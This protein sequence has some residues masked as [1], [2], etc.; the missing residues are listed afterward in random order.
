[1]VLVN[2]DDNQFLPGGG[3]FVPNYSYPSAGIGGGQ[4][5]LQGLARRTTL[6]AADIAARDQMLAGPA[7]RLGIQASYQGGGYAQPAIYNP[8]GPGFYSPAS[9]GMG[10]AVA[11]GGAAMLPGMMP[12]GGD[13]YGLGFS[14]YGAAMFGMPYAGGGPGFSAPIAR[15]L[16]LSS[17][18]GSSF[19][20]PF[21][22]GP[23]NNALWNMGLGIGANVMGLP[24][25]ASGGYSNPFDY[26]QRFRSAAMHGR[27]MQE[28]GQIMAPWGAASAAGVINTFN[29]AL[30]QSGSVGGL[31]PEMRKKIEDVLGVALPTA[32]G[33]AVTSPTGRAILDTAFGGL[34]YASIASTFAGMDRFMMPGHTGV[35]NRNLG[36]ASFEDL[37]AMSRGYAGFFLTNDYF[38]RDLKDLDLQDVDRLRLRNTMRGFTMGEIAPYLNYFARQGRLGTSVSTFNLARDEDFIQSVVEDTKKL[39]EMGRIREEYDKA[40]AEYHRL[41]EQGD[42][43]AA[44]RA[45]QRANELAD[46]YQQTAASRPEGVAD[47]LRDQGLERLRAIYANRE[48]LETGQQ[49]V[50]P[51]TGQPFNIDEQLQMAAGERMAARTADMIQTLGALRDIF[52]DQGVAKSAAELFDEFQKFDS[53]YGGKLK[54]GQTATMLYQM[55]FELDQLGAGFEQA[56][57]LIQFADT[58]SNQLGISYVHGGAAATSALTYTR[59]MTTAGTFQFEGFGTQNQEEFLLQRTERS[60]KG[61]PS[62]AGRLLATI[63]NMADLGMLAGPGAERYR[64]IAN[65][66]RSGMPIS[67]REF[68][69][70]METGGVGAVMMDLAAAAGTSTTAI[71]DLM[72]NT[73]SVESAASQYGG[74]ASAITALQNQELARASRRFASVEV[75]STASQYMQGVDVSRRGRLS[76][77]LVTGVQEILQEMDPTIAADPKMRRLKTSRQLL[78]RLKKSGNPAAQQFLAQYRDASGNLDEQR[79]LKDLQAMAGLTEL[80]ESNFLGQDAAQFHSQRGRAATEAADY[81]RQQSAVQAELEQIF[82]GKSPASFAAGALQDLLFSDIGDLEGQIDVGEAKEKLN[83]LLED[84]LQ[85]GA[86]GDL[87]SEEMGRVRDFVMGMVESRRAYAETA[88]ISEAQKKEILNQSQMIED[89]MDRIMKEWS[90]GR[91]SAKDVQIDPET[92]KPIL[93]DVPIEHQKAI[94]EVLQVLAEKGFG[95][96]EVDHITIE[97]N[98]EPI[99]DSDDARINMDDRS[100]S[101]SKGK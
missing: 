31:S 21:I 65:E 23:T 80:A 39:D 14:D 95:P 59:G 83:T 87:N 96:I 69:Q 77:F 91:R 92:G 1:M 75:A 26:S 48:V 58:V 56:G 8:G 73:F 67:D 53:R 45:R 90:T 68:L 70:Q 20:R 51:R 12:A 32:A 60:L 52:K 22:P 64:R 66:I 6:S 88:D 74:F 49:Q 30:A 38:N 89:S 97:I 34:G 94:E 9:F 100:T 101:K 25:S 78:E 82:S 17:S 15:Y 24:L 36:V 72:Q 61:I 35:M 93:S 98:G 62:E 86:Y 99:I 71:Q 79:A 2:Y 3:S 10:A 85:N 19:F 41:Q 84:A 16:G 50:D 5:D 55:A 47:F 40:T 63:A 4:A 37:S 43:E 76:E 27:M 42:Q 13:L 57:K 81:A 46:Q 44:E 11:I 28:A 18:Y 29:T 54:A 7:S 33:M